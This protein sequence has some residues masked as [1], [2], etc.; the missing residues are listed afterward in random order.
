MIKRILFLSALVGAGLLSADP[1]QICVQAK[2]LYAKKEYTRALELYQS[3]EPKNSAI[4]YNIGNCLYKQGDH[5][6]ALVHW[7]RASS[8]A[9]SDLRDD[10][11]CNIMRVHE[12][13][14]TTESSQASSLQD[15]NT[16]F[17][18]IPLVIV[19]LLFLLIWFLSIFYFIK[20]GRRGKNYRFVLGCM[21]I[22]L[23]M[24]AGMITVNYVG[25]NKR[26]A[27]VMKDAPLFAGPNE[28]Y[29]RMA[30]LQKAACVGVAH[31]RDGWA[32]IE[33][34]NQVGWVAADS[35][36]IV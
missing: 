13:I 24:V 32:K 28:H 12:K 19:Q 29:N 8:G 36:A 7:A 11:A 33:Y 3:V 34:Q 2:A 25:S 21:Y 27:L 9:S 23:V 30:V 26:I 16:V 1:Q 14:G 6:N 20:N 10:I 4:W 35:V 5:M 22:A 17:T 31:M 18:K 15:V